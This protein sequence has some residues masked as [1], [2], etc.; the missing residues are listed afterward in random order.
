[1]GH[2]YCIRD[3]YALHRMQKTIIKFMRVVYDQ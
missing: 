1:M 3:L 2:M